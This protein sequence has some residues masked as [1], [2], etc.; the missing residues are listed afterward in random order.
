MAGSYVPQFNILLTDINPSIV[1]GSNNPNLIGE[2]REDPGNI[3]M[4]LTWSTGD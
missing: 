2:E 1:F 4:T 3:G